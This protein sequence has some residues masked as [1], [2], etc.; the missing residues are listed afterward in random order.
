MRTKSVSTARFLKQVVR[1]ILSNLKKTNH[2]SQSINLTAA[3]KTHLLEHKLENK[4]N[5]DDE[6]SQEK[7]ITFNQGYDKEIIHNAFF[8]IPP[9]KYKTVILGKQNK[10]VAQSDIFYHHPRFARI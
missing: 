3:D 2:I 8:I 10:P 1:S 9:E 5:F 6:F 4:E 7:N